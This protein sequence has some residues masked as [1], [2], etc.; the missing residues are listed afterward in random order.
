MAKLVTL[1]EQDLERLPTRTCQAT[2]VWAGSAPTC[3]SS[4]IVGILC[5]CMYTVG[6]GI[7]PS[8][9]CQPSGLHLLTARIIPRVQLCTVI[10]LQ[11]PSA[12]PYN[13]KYSQSLNFVVWS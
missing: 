1:L 6:S 12:L 8:I 7:N 10:L 4:L 2:G 3:Q 11:G 9:K 13:Q 5:M